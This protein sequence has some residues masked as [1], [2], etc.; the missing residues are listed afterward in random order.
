MDFEEV[1]ASLSSRGILLDHLGQVEDGKKWSACVRKQGTTKMGN[2]YG[3]TVDGAVKAALSV[4]RD[5]FSVTEWKKMAAPVNPTE[6][7]K[8]K[9]VRVKGR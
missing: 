5:R 1:L 7:K 2:G 8:R 9:R 6:P 3:K 4:M